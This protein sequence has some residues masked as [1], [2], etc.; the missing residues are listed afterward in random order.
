[1]EYVIGWI[2]T[3]SGKRDEFMML[4][5]PFIAATRQ[6]DGILFFELHP[7][8]GN[9]DL[10]VATE[11]YATAEAHERHV[12]TP[13]FAVFWEAFQRLVLD[14]RFENIFADRTRLDTVKF[15]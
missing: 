12:R 3:R 1:M 9:P 10:V 7:S 2:T 8:A 14:G 6:E 11:G 15:D 4:A 13:H 5:E